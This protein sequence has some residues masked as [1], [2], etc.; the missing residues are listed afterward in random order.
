MKL[1]E[2]KKKKKNLKKKK[3]KKLKKKKKKKP[4]PLHVPSNDKHNFPQLDREFY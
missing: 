3:K 2:K 1:I 4:G